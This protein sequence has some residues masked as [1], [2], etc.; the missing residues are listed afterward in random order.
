MVLTSLVLLDPQTLGAR[1]IYTLTKLHFYV[2]TL[3]LLTLNK[4]IVLLQTKAK[5]DKNNKVGIDYNC[6]TSTFEQ[7]LHIENHS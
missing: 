3:T 1:Q 2:V 4:I 6:M 7:C 5:A